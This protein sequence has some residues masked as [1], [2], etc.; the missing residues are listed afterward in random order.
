MVLTPHPDVSGRKRQPHRSRT[1]NHRQRFNRLAMAGLCAAPLIGSFFYRYGYRVPLLHCPLRALT[2]IPCPTCGMTRSFT[3]IAH[4]NLVQAAQQHLFGPFVFL[5]LAGVI[6]HLVWEL[7]TNQAQTA[8]Y[9]VLGKPILLYCLLGSYFGY[10]V[11]R[12]YGLEQSGSLMSTF[13]TS[14]MGLW[15]SHFG[16]A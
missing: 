1:L 15:F 7:Q 6:V 13:W 9:R 11:I 14:P 8:L 2:G 4:G 10:Y 3:A 12:L 16:A 5:L